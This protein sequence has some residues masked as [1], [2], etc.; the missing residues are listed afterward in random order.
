MLKYGC[1]LTEPRSMHLA[2]LTLHSLRVLPGSFREH[3]ASW[4]VRERV[5]KWEA[6]LFS[7]I[8]L[9]PGLRQSHRKCKE[10]D[11]IT[12]T[13]PAGGGQEVQSSPAMWGQHHQG[14]SDLFTTRVSLMQDETAPKTVSVF[15]SNLSYNH[16]I[17]SPGP[18]NI[19]KAES[20]PSSTSFMYSH[21]H[22]HTARFKPRPWAQ[23]LQPD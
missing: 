5:Y 21:T 2:A 22:T 9:W 16:Y 13:S 10:A 1:P 15:L 14:W 3:T 8:F 17:C 7:H 19:K 11:G 20:N 4:A 23:I 18:L 6:N 12:Q